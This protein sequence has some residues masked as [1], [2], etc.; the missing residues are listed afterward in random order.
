MENHPF[1]NGL[2]RDETGKTLQ[3]FRG[4]IDEQLRAFVKASLK[5]LDVR[6]TSEIKEQTKKQEDDI[7]TLKRHLC[8]VQF[9]LNESFAKEQEKHESWGMAYTCYFNS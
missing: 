8:I 4:E 9:D 1:F 6:L 3:T 7:L 5:D 2:L